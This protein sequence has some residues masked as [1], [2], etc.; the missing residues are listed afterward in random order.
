[1]KSFAALLIV[2]WTAETTFAHP[3]HSN[4]TEIEWNP[5]SGRFEV[6]MKLDAAGME[7][8]ISVDRKRVFRLESDDEP[9]SAVRK[10]V[11]AR[12]D[13]QHPDAHSASIRWV[14]HELELHAIWIYF[15]VIPEA[16][17][18]S[19]DGKRQPLFSP[20]APEDVEI[21]NSCLMDVRPETVHIITVRS[22]RRDRHAVCSSTRQKL[23]TAPQFLPR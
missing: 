8:A 18:S 19:G 22:G 17:E 6:A 5:E 9:D 7:D 23:P 1:M 16:K 15:E 10:Y 11:S 13:L 2:L 3:F 21:R 14:G 20:P 12:F 4:I